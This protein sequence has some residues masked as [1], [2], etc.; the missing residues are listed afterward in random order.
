MNDTIIIGSQTN[1]LW[2][3]TAD[4]VRTVTAVLSSSLIGDE[5][6]VDTLYPTIVTEAYITFH[7]AFIPSGS[8]GLIT[9]DGK[10][11]KCSQRGTGFQPPVPYATPVYW[12]RDGRLMGKFFAKNVLRKTKTDFQLTAVSAIGILDKQTHDGGIYR[13]ETFETVAA[14]I[15]GPNLPFECV[16]ALRT[17]RVYGWLPIASRRQNLHQLI[18]AMGCVIG[19]TADGDMFFQYPDT[20]VLSVPKDRIYIDGEV[21]FNTSANRIELTE[22]SYYSLDSDDVVTLFDN[23]DGSDTAVNKRVVFTDA[24]IHDLSASDG[25]TI[26]SSGPNFAVLNGT[27]VLTGKKY[28]HTTQLLTAT[29]PGDLLEEQT[30][31]VEQNTLVSMANSANVLQRLLSYYSSAKSISSDL[32]VEAEKPGQRISFTDPFDEPSTAFIASMDLNSSNALKGTCSLV[33]GYTPTG[34]GNNFN[35]AV[36]LTV[37]GKWTVPPGITLIRIIL[38]GAGQGGWSGQKGQD[39]TR[40][41]T[42]YNYDDI[43]YHGTN[44]GPPAKGGLGGDPGEGGKFLVLT[45]SVTPGQEIDFTRGVPGIGGE[46]SPDGSVPGTYGTDS[47]CTIGGKTYSSANGARSKTGYY[48]AFTQTTYSVPGR[49]GINGGNSMGRRADLTPATDNEYIP[50]PATTVV[51]YDGNMWIGGDCRRRTD[52]VKVYIETDDW[53]TP[54][55]N[56]QFEGAYA[57]ASVALGSGAAVGSNGLYGGDVISEYWPPYVNRVGSE[58]SY[59]YRA[60][61]YAP[62]GVNGADASIIPADATVPGCGGDAGHGGGAGGSPGLQEIGIRGNASVTEYNK[63]GIPGIGGKGTKGANGAGGY[64]LIIY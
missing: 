34:G 14:D 27:G 51:D 46:Y 31:P 33:T 19:K 8:S 47:T 2:T 3:L 63:P 13:G 25:L 5:L 38:G 28:T 55:G 10:R 16:E 62:D 50:E 41:D 53:I 49:R 12:M 57:A 43:Y 4:D 48:D 45:L 22:H 37:S 40:V 36:L 60:R 20:T 11:F 54:I 15:L 24:P 17:Q 39:G 52:D 9:K 30:I 6:A 21:S 26:V 29:Q 32:V 35:N 7:Y 61:A 59:T 42:S 58:G 64:L 18:F 23:T 1:P 44:Y 56:M